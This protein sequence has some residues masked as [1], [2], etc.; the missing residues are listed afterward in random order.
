MEWIGVDLA[1]GVDVVDKVDLRGE[2]A[3]NLLGGRR[4]EEVGPDCQILE[5]SAIKGVG[6]SPGFLFG[7][8]FFK[9]LPFVCVGFAPADADLHL[10]STIFPVEAKGD[11]G[12]SFYSR[13]FEQLGNFGFVQQQLPR[14]FSIVL[15]VAG[16]FVRLDVCVVEECFLVFDSR[17]GV[18]QVGEAGTNR[19][20]LGTSET[21][22]GFELLQDL[23]IVK[24]SPI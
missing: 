9:V 13:G 8:F 4:L 20:Y 12:L 24:C 14:A 23:V 10:H 11:E 2:A 17:E 6:G 1:D 16:A 15:L 3:T 5:F 18:T 19:F 7:R 21:D 22:T